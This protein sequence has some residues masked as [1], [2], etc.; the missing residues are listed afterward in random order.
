ME[1]TRM[2]TSPELTAQ[3]R[4][5]A[6]FANI[7]LCIMF[8]G[9]IGLDQS[10]KIQAEEVLMKSS[11]ETN[12]KIYTGRQ[13]PLGVLGQLQSERG[14]DSPFVYLGLNYVRNQGAAWGAMSTVADKFRIPF[15][16]AVTVLAIV[17]IGLYFRSTPIH[18]KT[19]RFALILVL[20]GAFGNFIDRV[21]LG[22]VI[23]WIDVRWNL[24]GWTYHF[25]NFNLADSAITM[26]VTLLL[27]DAVILETMRRSRLTPSAPVDQRIDS[28]SIAEGAEQAM[29]AK[30]SKTKI[31]V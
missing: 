12:L 11:H 15:F 20:S 24:L 6:R 18:H 22:Y 25:P 10:S 26:G 9:S 30:N 17:V 27:V 2:I 28:A 23:D 16:Y 21:R 31:E 13:I 29:A 14:E 1:N 5:F 4:F 19:A 8:I 7:A 3:N